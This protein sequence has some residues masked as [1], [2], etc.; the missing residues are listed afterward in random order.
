MSHDD[1]ALPNPPFS[2]D[3]Y[4]KKPRGRTEQKEIAG[5]GEE[6]D[7]QWRYGVQ[8][9]QDDLAET[10]LAQKIAMRVTDDGSQPPRMR[11]LI[12]LNPSVNDLADAIKMGSD[13]IV[14]ACETISDDENHPFRDL[15]VDYYQRYDP[16]ICGGYSSDRQASKQKNMGWLVTPALSKRCADSFVIQVLRL[17]EVCCGG[18]GLETS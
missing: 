3:G 11:Q 4:S 2:R 9:N 15:A 18:V 1:F 5:Y 10:K 13:W 6:Y 12:V 8:P 7:L 16:R 14:Q 17:Y